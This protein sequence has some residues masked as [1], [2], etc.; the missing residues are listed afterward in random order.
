MHLRHLVIREIAHRTGAFALAVLVVAA[1]AF[2]IVVTDWILRHDAIA[3]RRIL[4][5]TQE[6]SEVA[7]ADK[8]RAVEAAGAD[9][10]D[11]I[12]RQM[13][14]LGFNVLIL[15]AAQDVS[16]LHLQ[17]SL[18]E[19]MPEAYVEKLANSKIMTVNHL[20]PTVLRKVPWPEREIDV[21]LYGTRGEVPLVHQTMKKP[22]LDAVAPGQMVL[23]HAIHTR[24]GLAAGDRVTFH[25]REFTVSRLH[26][27]RGSTDD[28]TVWIDLATAQEILGLQNLL[29][30]I[31]ALECG[32]EGDRIA[33]IRA[34]IA[35]IL[36]GT[37]VIERYSQALAR[38]EARTQA[39]RSAEQALV[40]EQ[41]AAAAT[42]A[43]ER[44]ARANLERQRR[45]LAAFV[46]P[47][48]MLAAAAAVG[49]LAYANVRQR[50]EEIGLLRALGLRGGQIFAVFLGKAVLC[51][52]LGGGL[53][54]IAGLAT[55][56]GLGPGLAAM[57][58]V[59]VGPDPVFAS[60]GLWLTVLLTPLVAVAL[61]TLASWVAAA[62]AARQDAAMVLQGE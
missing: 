59:A 52:L 53:G 10:E 26:P 9:L 18:T 19:T 6:A 24:L 47:A 39:K 51:G 28:V 23:G 37:Q 58:P 50:R 32:C 13:L 62:T 36:P 40:A 34:E 29:H 42:L 15:P 7:I 1:A 43:R 60:R 16:E 54:V 20:L 2:A 5:R 35:G 61:A 8:L 12:R 48:V 14:A 44:A 49:F 30:G 11:T 55:A 41:E 46:L 31:L 21:I 22:L 57:E 4:A 45:R 3:T 17:G 38:A 56:A 27:E 33:Q 25:G